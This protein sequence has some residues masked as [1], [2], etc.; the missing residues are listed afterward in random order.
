MAIE[1][2]HSRNY[3][4]VP[5]LDIQPSVRPWLVKGVLP[6]RGVG[7]IVGAS[8][9]GKSF[10]AIDFALRMASG[11]K[12][13]GRTT[14]QCGVVYLAAEDEE[15]C[16]GRITAWRRQFRRDKPTP[17]HLF[18]HAVNLLDPDDV[19]AWIDA[20]GD[21]AFL[22]NEGDVPLGMIVVDTL[23]C[24]LPGMNENSSESM[25]LALQSL[26]RIG[27][28]FSCLVLVVAHF[29]KAGEDKG[30][31]GWSGMDAN[32]DATITVE[33]SEE[34]P[35]LRI[36]KLAKVKNGRDG[37][38]VNFRLDDV[39]LGLWDEDGDPVTSCVVGYEK[40]V[41]LAKKKRHK[42][43]NAPES[44]VFQ[45]IRHLTDHGVTQPIPQTIA[46]IKPWHKGLRRGDIVIQLMGGG[47]SIEGESQD[48]TR[49]RLY[50]A[51][52][53]LIQ[54]ERIRLES[55]LIWLI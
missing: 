44:I 41:P 14:K 32:S 10:L 30:I 48:S 31:R 52:Q 34:D 46:G 26:R 22:F 51:L 23:A 53:G 42:A 50:R 7:F 49:K 43:M 21:S 11:A 39:D 55:D 47:F 37:A 27:R 28:H 25:S 36:M 38:M 12:V 16:A 40:A 15:G 19:T 9:A 35:D 29:G 2:V 17:F 13:L 20:I 6:Q 5:Y 24:C 18:T 54:Q 45:A 1:L 8:K 3:T 33:R 4:G